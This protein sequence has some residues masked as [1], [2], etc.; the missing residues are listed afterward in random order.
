V[1]QPQRWSGEWH[2]ADVQRWHHQGR[3]AIMSAQAVCASRWV[4]KNGH[5]FVTRNVDT[6]CDMFF[7]KI[8]GYLHPKELTLD[9]REWFWIFL[10]L[11]Q[12]TD[13][14]S[15]SIYLLWFLCSNLCSQTH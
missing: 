9:M 2:G 12:S 6:K 13:I 4:E 5:I 1:R 15:V 3:A 11:D 10:F 7:S 8:I 14:C